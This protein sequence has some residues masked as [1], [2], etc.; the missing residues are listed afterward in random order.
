MKHIFLIFLVIGQVLP[1]KGVT[2]MRLEWQVGHH[3]TLNDSPREWMPA[4]VPGAVQLDYAAFNQLAPY[5][6]GDHWRDYE[7][8]ENVYWS[9][10]CSF[11]APQIDEGERLYFFSQGIDYQ[12]IITFNG[13]QM[14]EQEGMFTPVRLDLTAWLQSDNTLQVTIFP[15]PKSRQTPVDRSQADQSVKPA[16]SYGW[17]WHPRLIPLGIWDDT[18]IEIGRSI[19]YQ[20]IQIDY[21][22]NDD[23]T[24]ADLTLEMDLP[25]SNAT[26]YQWQ[27]YH[28]DGDQVFEQSSSIEQSHLCLKHKVTPVSLWWPHD[29]GTPALYTSVFTIYRAQERLAE[30]RQRIGFRSV[31][32]VMNAGAWDEP[33]SFPMTRSVPPIQIEINGRHIFAKGSNWVPPEIFP[34]I[35]TRNHYETLLNLAVEAHFNILRLWGGGIVNKQAFFDLCDEKGVLLW[36]DFPLACNDYRGTPHYLSVLEQ[37]A[38]S[39]IRKL[40]PHPSLVLWCGGN[41]LF[42]AWSGM[43]DQSSALRLLNAL[44]YHLD[45][46]RP[47]IMTS[48]QM[49]IGHG[50]YVF[51]D[52]DSGE[53][54]FQLMKRARQTAYTEFGVPSP[55]PV[56]LLKTF[57]PPEHRWP[58][59]PDTV[60]QSHHAFAAWKGETWLVPSTIEHYFGKQETLEQLVANGQLL[61]SEGY[62]CIYESARR[63]KPYCSMALNWCYN[64]PWPTAANNS[65][66]N[67]P[68]DPKPAFYAVQSSCRPILASARFD[69]FIWHEGENFTT[70]IWLLNDSHEP[71]TDAKVVVRLVGDTI[72]ESQECTL[73]AAEAN[74]NVVGPTLQWKLPGWQSDRFQLLLEV[75]GH[76]EWNSTY[77]LLYRRTKSQ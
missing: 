41:E 3:Q 52:L 2:A 75:E 30:Y 77:T 7:W 17:D 58:P 73:S 42:N 15:A 19:Q 59:R 49:G 6:Y 34:G 44:C 25:P 47:F 56:A 54:V 35:I 76:P 1:A 32:L 8:M 43:T 63:Q 66:I 26:H 50:N 65:L 36:Q 27:L 69:K 9:Y 24:A 12:F 28:P 13:H 38:G 53:E 68:H 31:R 45:P 74:S 33:R 46:Q 60:W 10:R 67:W 14:L 20:N 37:E 18:G 21:E 62:K 72:V 39:I 64:E 55:S 4:T 71:V 70:D 16:V 11:A 57:I 22:L 5:W 29:Q 40:K 48:P 61:Q 23:L 51:R